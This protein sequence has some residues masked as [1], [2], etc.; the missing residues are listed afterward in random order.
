VIST[1][2]LEHIDNSVQISG[3]YF[4][5]GIYPSVFVADAKLHGYV[6]VS[7]HGGSAL[8]NST[9]LLVTYGPTKKVLH[10]RLRVA[11]VPLRDLPPIAPCS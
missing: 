8:V 2:H 10:P 1:R 9:A 7:T 6:Q 3:R 11:L 5:F 4:S